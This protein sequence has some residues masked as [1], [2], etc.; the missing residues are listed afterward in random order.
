VRKWSSASSAK[1]AAKS[2]A[3]HHF[4]D[5]IRCVLA[6]GLKRLGHAALGVPRGVHHLERRQI[7]QQGTTAKLAL[8]KI[9]SV[10]RHHIQ[11]TSEFKSHNPL[12]FAH[13]WLA[14]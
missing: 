3:S 7:A 6:V 1:F 14:T 4:T 12:Y 13:K 11:W 5:L 10:F 8:R 2:T 9:I